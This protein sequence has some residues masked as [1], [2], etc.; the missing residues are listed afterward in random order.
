[1]LLVKDQC[2]LFFEN[3]FIIWI[4]ELLPGISF[5]FHVSDVI[6]SAFYDCDF[7]YAIMHHF[8]SFCSLF[9]MDGDYAP[10]VELANL[11]KKHGFLLVIDD[12]SPLKFV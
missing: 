8:S 2:G 12:V 10:M 6:Y 1:M 5:F 7:L 3:I 9:S 11:R 4:S